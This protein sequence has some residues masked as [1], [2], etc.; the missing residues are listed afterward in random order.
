M[1]GAVLS[2]RKCGARTRYEA[3]YLHRQRQDVLAID[4]K[5]SKT[6]KNPLKTGARANTHDTKE[7]QT[8]DGVE[9]TRSS[10]LSEEKKI[11]MSGFMKGMN[12]LCDIYD[13]DFKT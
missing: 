8:V 7:E 3:F 1:V 10:T 6:T 5:K 2:V 11:V 4:V 9:P 12:L 13:L